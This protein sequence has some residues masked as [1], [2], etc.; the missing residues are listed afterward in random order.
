MQCKD[1]PDEP[2][3]RWLSENSS[4]HKWTT[5]GSN[6]CFMPTVQDV[7]PKGT[8]V[9]LQ[10]AKMKQLIKRKLVNGCGCGCRGDFYLTDKGKSF[11]LEKG[12]AND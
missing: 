3:L 10:L 5:Y 12:K 11:C 7:M 1:I 8:L 6:F 9:K 2:I 4:E